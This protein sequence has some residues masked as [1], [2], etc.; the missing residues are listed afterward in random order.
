MKSTLATYDPFA[1]FRA[2]DAFFEKLWPTTRVATTALNTSLPIGIFEKDGTVFVR[3]S[4]PGINPGDIDIS[5]ENNILTIRGECKQE[6]EFAEAKVYRREY[7]HGT[8]S[9]SVRLP[10]NLDFEKID[11]E[12]KNGMVTIA[13]PMPA[14]PQ[15]KTVKVPLRAHQ[16]VPL[17][18]KN[19]TEKN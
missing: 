18:A 8:F 9:R 11:A 4:V 16:T 1:D 10:E 14:E 2:M 13:I 6:E 15:P 3:A 17:E 7:A 5:I 19:K 12:F